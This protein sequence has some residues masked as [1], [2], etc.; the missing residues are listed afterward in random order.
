[1]I[2]IVTMNV[3]VGYELQVRQLGVDLATSNGQPYYPIYLFGPYK[4]A[5]VAAGCAISFFWVIFPYPITAKSQLRKMLGSGLFTLAQFYSC[6]HTTVELWLNGELGT[7]QDVRSSSDRLASK[8]R[9]LFRQEMTLLNALRMHSH[10]STFEPAIG[11]KFPKSI[12]DAIISETQKIVTSMALMAQTTQNMKPVS[13]SLPVETE[14]SHKKWASRLAGIALDS[15]DF[16]SHST[17]SLLC[18]LASALTNAQPLPPLLSAGHPFPLARR[19][20]WIDNQL[21]SIRHIEDPAFS[22]FVSLEV[23]RTVV[24]YSLENLLRYVQSVVYMSVLLLISCK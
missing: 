2:A 21:L 23:L 4:L 8:R 19:M 22:T 11:G 14:N 15:E 16:K 5:T 9:K 7:V 20:Q 3:I 10:F 24:N 17:T 13:G 6:M 18:H 12:Y 1:M